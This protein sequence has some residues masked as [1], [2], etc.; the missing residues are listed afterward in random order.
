[1]AGSDPTQ[2]LL[3]I[4]SVAL[5]LLL[6]FSGLVEKPARELDDKCSRLRREALPLAKS[7]EVKLV[8][9][10]SRE[11]RP[12]RVRLLLFQGVGSL[13]IVKQFLLLG[14]CPGHA[15]RLGEFTTLVVAYGLVLS[16]PAYYIYRSLV[17]SLL[18]FDSLVLLGL[19]ALLY[20]RLRFLPSQRLYVEQVED[21]LASLKALDQLFS[22]A[23]AA[24]PE[25]S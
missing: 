11:A 1:M 23:E 9:Y 14:K 4:S 2:L 6:Q 5:A 15:W 12:E 25:E 18:L 17:A 24:P 3:F 8:E 21:A 10:A 7:M 16:I 13:A 22:D 19:L 20:I